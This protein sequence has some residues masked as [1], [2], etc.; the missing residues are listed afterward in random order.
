MKVRPP[1]RS[2][3]SKPP[4]EWAFR[5]ATIVPHDPEKGSQSEVANRMAWARS[6]L[7]KAGLLDNSEQGVWFLAEKCRNTENVDGRTIAREFR[8]GLTA[9]EH[10]S[11][12]GNIA[13]T[14]LFA[15]N[16]KNIEWATLDR[17][18]LRRAILHRETRM[19]GARDACVLR[20]VNL[21]VL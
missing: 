1:I 9:H 18:R 6:Y 19:S 10:G 16:P 4:R 15:W 3:A 12:D 13:E 2:W 8:G 14:Y 17:A 11:V 20:L 7:K 21:L 5:R